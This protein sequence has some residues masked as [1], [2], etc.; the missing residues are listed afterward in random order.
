MDKYEGLKEFDAAFDPKPQ[1]SAAGVWKATPEQEAI[2]DAIAGDQ[3]VVVRALA[4]TGK[5]TVAVKGNDRAKGRRGF[6]AFNKH[7]AD[8]LGR[9]L[10][11]NA[12][13]CTLHSLG[14]AANN[15]VF[16]HAG[17]PDE[18]KT[19]RLLLESN[20]MRFAYEDRRGNLRPTSEAIEIL[21]AARFC[22]L[23]LTDPQNDEAFDGMVEHFGLYDLPSDADKI[24]GNLLDRC[25]QLT[26]TR[27]YTDMVWLPV[28]RNLPVEQF[29]Y[30][31][32]DE[33]QDLNRCQQELAALACKG[34][35]M[36]PIGDELQS[37]YGFT[38]ADPESMPR[39]TERL[40]S[41]AR[42]ARVMPMTVTF[43]CPRSHVA[44][45]NRLVPDLKA[46]GEAAEGKIEDIDPERVTELAGPGD[47]IIC[48][49]NAP[50][51]GQTFALLAAGKP[52]VMLG[53]DFG[54]GLTALLNK[55]NPGTCDEL[56]AKVRKWLDKEV[57]RLE[58]KRANE[59]AVQ[60]ATD[61]A[62]CL[63]ELAS[64]EDSVGAVRDRIKWLSA[65]SADPKRSIRLSSV[66][67]AKGSEADRIIIVEPECM[68]MISKKTKSWEIQQEKNILYVALTRAKS[69]LYFA[70]PQPAVLGG[71]AVS[72]RQ[73]KTLRPERPDPFAAFDRDVEEFENGR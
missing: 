43:R 30:L 47:L 11:T 73:M 70:G 4:G 46:A 7:I 54:K 19:E 1:E 2:Y 26:K 23:T 16:G 68:P 27:D 72:P 57:D 20:G 6:V 65:E 55:L 38:G 62:A 67:R 3:N 36:A 50:L 24:I 18:N 48:R 5:T 9:R 63:L 59:S 34:G 33:V 45:A 61:K 32:V 51:V 37:L 22:R 49:K 44:L 41:S 60:S 21:N 42:G 64:Y 28:V 31:A 15:R 17:D 14:N 66:H 25:S 12:K 71:P 39:L 8:E 58:R 13:S 10:G 35:R 56:I 53:R 52:A 69:E 29:D 40:R